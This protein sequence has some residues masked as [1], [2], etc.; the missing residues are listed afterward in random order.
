MAFCLAPDLYQVILTDFSLIGCEHFY[1]F[2]I[3]GGSHKLLTDLTGTKL[4]EYISYVVGGTFT[5][6]A[7][8]LQELLE[9]GENDGNMRWQEARSDLGRHRLAS[10]RKAVTPG[11]CAD[12]I[13]P[14]GSV[15]VVEELENGT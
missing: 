3:K 12:S 9:S 14:R 6:S 1:Q 7:D 8:F 4:V 10:A 11:R 15:L 2:V 5:D 13:D